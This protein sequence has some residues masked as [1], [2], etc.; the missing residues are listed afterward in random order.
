MGTEGWQES[1]GRVGSDGWAPPGAG[2]EEELPTSPA[3][4]S[5]LLGIP[6]LCLS[7][8]VSLQCHPAYCTGP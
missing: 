1:D 4:A 7:V 2:E 3:L 6:P 5:H 8:H